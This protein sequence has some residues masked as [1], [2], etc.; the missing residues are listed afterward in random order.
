MK[1]IFVFTV[2]FV[3][4]SSIAAY[5]KEWDQKQVAEVAEKVKAGKGVVVVSTYPADQ[6][7]QIEILLARV[8]YAI[9]IRAKLC[10]A[11]PMAQG[12]AGMVQVPCKAIKDGYP[13]I[14]PIIDWEK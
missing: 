11:T 2:I 3:L 9:D 4:A 14:A 7:Q 1:K 13:V 10:F 5:A 6:V 12:D 8:K